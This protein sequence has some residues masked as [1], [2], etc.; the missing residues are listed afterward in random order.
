[1][2]SVREKKFIPY[3]NI[4]QE[5]KTV[6]DSITVYNN[7]IDDFGI[8]KITESIKKNS[9]FTMKCLSINFT[10]LTNRYLSSKKSYSGIIVC[11]LLDDQNIEATRIDKQ[12]NTVSK[13][14]KKGSLVVI[15]E[16]FRKSWNYNIPPGIIFYEHNILP[17]I[18]SKIDTRIKYAQK[19]KSILGFLNKFPEWDKCIQDHINL[20]LVGKGSY[21]SVFKARYKKYY[22]AVKLSKYTKKESNV[23]NSKEIYI[24]EKIIKPFVEQKICPNLPLISS[25]GGCEKEKKTY[26]TTELANGNLRE[27]IIRET[28]NQEDLEG[29]L[30]QCMAGLHC[31]QQHAQLINYDVKKDNILYYDVVPGGYWCYVIFG[32]KYYIKNFGKLF[33]LNDFGVSYSTDINLCCDVKKN[34]IPRLGLRYATIKNKKFIP[35]EGISFTDYST[36][37]KVSCKKINWEDGKV[38][39]GA[40][41]FM[42]DGKILPVELKKGDI[43]FSINTPPFDFYNDTQDAIR[44][45]LGGKRT[46]QKGDHRKVDIPDSFRKKLEPYVGKGESAKNRMFDRPALTIAGYFIEEFFKNYTDIPKNSFLI[47]TY[48]I[49]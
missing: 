18:Y 25:Y 37:E 8:E 48:K 3:N 19:I 49:S 46:T 5:N 33:I 7:L 1:M 21:G 16:N 45:F 11:L 17:I 31:V 32:K 14:V 20:D 47:E 27:Y 10:L 30:F 44:M 41:F 34:D 29:C 38:C 23:I 40:E 42:K 43:D 9:T 4:T 22:Y 15:G 28:P 26:I 12:D 6:F 36:Q 13:I 24:M 2:I 39:H 35:I